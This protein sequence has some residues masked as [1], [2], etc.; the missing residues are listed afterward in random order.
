[1]TG[2]VADWLEDRAGLR[3]LWRWFADE[4][5]PGGA[6]IRYVFG[7]VLIYLFMQ[8]FALGV[9]LATYYSP[10]ST[11]AWA[12][13][14]YLNDQVA[15]GWFI[16]GLHNHGASAM[17]VLLVLHTAQVI[18]AGAYRRPRELA[19][20]SGLIM[21]VV[22]LAMAFTGYLLPWDQKGYWATQ[23]AM[24][25]I[26]SLPVGEGL[27]SFLLGGTEFGN[28]TLTRFYAA[29]VFVLPVTLGLLLCIHIL[30]FRRHGVTPP[31]SLSDADLERKARPFSPYQLFLD[32]A[33]MAFAGAILVVWTVLTHGVEL[34]AP[35]QPSSNFVA[36]PEWYFLSLFQALHYLQGPLQLIATFVVP[37]TAG[38]FMFALPWLDR[39]KD[40]RLRR[41]WPILTV[42]GALMSG[43]IALTLVAVAADANDEL[44]QQGLADAKE[45]AE[46]A[47]RLAREGVAPKGGEAVFENDPK[48]RARMLFDDHCGACHEFDHKGGGGEGPSLTDYASRAWLAG[49][50]RN[51]KDARYFGLTKHDEMD[52]Y[53]KDRM[54]NEDLAALVEYLISQRGDGNG[55]F[56]RALARKGRV[57]FEDEQDCSF[58]HELEPGAAGSGPNLHG[59][60][61]SAWITRVIEDPSGEDLYGSSAQMPKYVDKLER[62][63]IELLAELLIEPIRQDGGAKAP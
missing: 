3:S 57:V 10:S 7:S 32:I 13:T 24:G 47:R 2:R 48:F 8:Q 26:G 12:S 9:L 44:Y 63:E 16:R 40:R 59:Y 49:M 53:P 61:T 33:A 14:A 31:A 58:C 41:R 35:A 45:Q 50:I 21:A 37:A 55:N 54:S 5:V 34:Y 29:H 4:P 30:V 60:A 42:A 15:A 27:Q 1:V 25:I 38:I 43:I 51:P 62:S 36:R 19:W 18:V 11:D 6:R 39:A 56:D 46:T 22:V 23:V 52:P 17:V 20:W 28:L